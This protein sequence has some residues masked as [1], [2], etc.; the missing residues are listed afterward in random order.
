MREE[1]MHSWGNPW[2][3]WSVVS[4][5][6]LTFVNGNTTSESWRRARVGSET[7]AS[8]DAS[9]RNSFRTSSAVWTR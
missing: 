7:F 5:V 9:R 1:G 6:V 4:L 3:R 2:F 8:P